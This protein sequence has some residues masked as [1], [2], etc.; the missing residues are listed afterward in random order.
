MKKI[1][2]ALILAAVLG[3]VLAPVASAQPKTAP[4]GCTLGDKVNITECKDFKSTFC[5][6]DGLDLAGGTVEKCPGIC[7]LLN[8]VFTITDWL[9]YILTLVVVL[10]VIYGGFVI[11]TASGDPEKA[12]KGRAILTYAIIGLA[13]AL[14]AKIIPSVV[15]FIMGV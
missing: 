14:L 2:T 10:M 4:N 5:S 13:V 12:G 8:T 3:V 6:Q 7:C 1:L 15:Q 11:L 9:F